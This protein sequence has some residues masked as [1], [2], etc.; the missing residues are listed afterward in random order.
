MSLLVLW[1]GTHKLMLLQGD[2][3]IVNVTHLIRTAKEEVLL[4]VGDRGVYR[5]PSK[6]VSILNLHKGIRIFK[7]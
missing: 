4:T 1:L 5:H 6:D 7:T 2:L 3:P